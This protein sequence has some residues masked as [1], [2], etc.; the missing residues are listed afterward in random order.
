MAEKITLTRP[1]DW[2][3]HLRDGGAMASAA[4]GAG[5]GRA[6]WGGRR[7]RG[8]GRARSRSAATDAARDQGR[9]AALVAHAPPRRAAAGR[10]VRA[11]NAALSHR[12]NKRKSTRQNSIHFS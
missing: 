6:G 11:D 4:R 9:A 7:G 5:G 1:D 8:A 3:L 12:K 10:A 2:H